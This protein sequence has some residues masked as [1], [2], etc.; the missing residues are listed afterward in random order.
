MSGVWSLQCFQIEGLSWIATPQ[1]SR[2]HEADGGKCGSFRGSNRKSSEEK[3]AHAW[4]DQDKR[5][6]KE[7]A[8]GDQAI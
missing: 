7:E 5:H 3:E 2:P 6:Q 1:D 8:M 4:L